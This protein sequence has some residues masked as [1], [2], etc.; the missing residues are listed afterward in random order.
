MG[1]AQIVDTERVVEV[2]EVTADDAMA[3]AQAH[4]RA[5]QAGYRGLIAQDYL[6]GLQP[7]EW[8]RRYDFDADASGRH[9]LV[10]VDGDVVC[11][12]VTYGRSRDGDMA[13]CAE[14]W[15]L[16]VDPPMWSTGIGRALIDAACD[17]LERAGHERVYL[18]VLSANM[19][20]RRF[21]ER[22]GLAC[23]RMRTDRRHRRHPGS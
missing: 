21:Y 4:V 2:R 9:T 22:V 12:H 14:I 5:W 16:Y 19:R 20:A 3:I 10:A 13:D 11:G 6:D 15:A 23:R 17:Q 7:T 8:A 1:T 18:W